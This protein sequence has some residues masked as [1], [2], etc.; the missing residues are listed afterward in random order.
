MQIGPKAPQQKRAPPRLSASPIAWH[1]A[2]SC[3]C[4]HDPVK[5]QPE[6]RVEDNQ[7]R[8]KEDGAAWK[9]PPP[10]LWFAWLHRFKLCLHRILPNARNPQKRNRR[11]YAIFPSAEASNT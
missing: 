9:E 6:R 10:V 8:K 7:K 5:N 4:D 3:S 1:S 2:C 11:K